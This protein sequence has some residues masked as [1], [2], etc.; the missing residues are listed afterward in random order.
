MFL[1]CSQRR[2]LLHLLPP[3]HRFRRC[4]CVGGHSRF[5]RHGHVLLRPA[6]C[7]GVRILSV[8]ARLHV[9]IRRRQVTRRPVAKTGTVGQVRVNSILPVTVII[10]TS[11]LGRFRLLFGHSCREVPRPHGRKE[12]AAVTLILVPSLRQ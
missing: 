11:G 5:T 4:A 6:L 9:R 2:R 3:L 1:P 8:V 10:R 12:K 7:E